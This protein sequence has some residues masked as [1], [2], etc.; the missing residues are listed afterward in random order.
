MNA[1]TDLL[2]W[3]LFL[4][5][6]RRVELYR[7]IASSETTILTTERSLEALVKPPFYAC[8]PQPFSNRLNLFSQA[9]AHQSTFCQPGPTSQSLNFRMWLAY[10]G[11]SCQIGFQD[12]SSFSLANPFSVTAVVAFAALIKHLLPSSHSA[13]SVW[14]SSGRLRCVLRPVRIPFGRSYP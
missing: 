1:L 14:T 7:T 6:H 10:R 4:P 3:I 11:Y 9:N 5:N 2:A 8:V 13:I 12:R